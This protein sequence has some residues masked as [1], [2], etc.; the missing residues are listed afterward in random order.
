MA[1]GGPVVTKPD[2]NGAPVPHHQPHPSPFTKGVQA[3]EPYARNPLFDDPYFPRHQHRPRPH[4]SDVR[5]YDVE[6][7]PG[8]RSRSS[9]PVLRR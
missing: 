4:P 8:R 6:P 1:A 5:Y 9:S 7:H 2:H 3:D